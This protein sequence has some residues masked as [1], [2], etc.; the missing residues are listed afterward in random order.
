M[1]LFGFVKSWIVPLTEMLFPWIYLFPCRSKIY[2][3]CVLAVSYMCV[4]V[5]VLLIG[6]IPIISRTLDKYCTSVL[7]EGIISLPEMQVYVIHQLFIRVH[8]FIA[9]SRQSPQG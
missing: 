7:G 9:A 6:L 3:L 2:L 8:A 4:D 5:V 1:C